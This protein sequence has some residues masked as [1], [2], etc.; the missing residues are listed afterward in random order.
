MGLQEMDAVQRVMESGHLA[1]GPE[2]KKFEV[3]WA[4]YLNAF[5]AVLVS[6]GTTALEGALAALR[7][8]NP[9]QDEVIVPAMS[10]NATSSA[11][12]AAGLRPVF[13]D[14]SRYSNAIDVKE[15]EKLRNRRT[16]GVIAVDLYGLMAD[17]EELNALGLPII[18]DAA[19]AHGSTYRGY[20]PGSVEMFARYPNLFATTFSFYATKNIT[21]GGEGGAVV[22]SRW[23]VTDFV[24]Q[25]REHGQ[26][27]RYNH[28]TA[29][30]NWRVTE[31]QAA[32]GRAQLKKLDFWQDIRNRNAQAYSRSLD[33]GGITYMIDK[34][35][36]KDDLYGH[37]WHQYVIRPIRE[38][39]DLTIKYL[40]ERGVGTG[41]HYPV[42]DPRQPMYGYAA[43]SFP[44]AEALAQ[45]AISIPVGP[46]VEPKD[47]TFIIKT[48]NESQEWVE[49][50]YRDSS[51]T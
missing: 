1:G 39:R 45:E 32:I 44:N 13:A 8:G 7:E 31:L 24:R 33:E 5:D 38:Y 51:D 47:V 2:S 22:S 12:I 15:V 21:T 25:L 29:G 48:I 19:Q 30:H 16:L 4:N 27:G 9:Y 40:N 50:E 35:Y 23:E 3:E 46:W 41:I 28:E 43:H 10:F 36:F 17:Y 42:A 18:E 6:N 14:I 49:K 20:K 11:V 34:P 37:G 26:R